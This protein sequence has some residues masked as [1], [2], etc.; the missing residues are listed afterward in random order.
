[1]CET[2]LLLLEHSAGGRDILSRTSREPSAV[3]GS[4]AGGA[5]YVNLLRTVDVPAAVAGGAAAAAA[6]IVAMC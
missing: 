2:T 6:V 4:S 3:T 5:E 1:M